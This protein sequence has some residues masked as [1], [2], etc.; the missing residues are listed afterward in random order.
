MKI[1]I[2]ETAIADVYYNLAAEDILCQ[3]VSSETARGE[4]LCGMFLWQSDK[5]VVIGR[6]QNPVREC[7]MEALRKNQ[8]KLARRLTGGGA[9]YQDLGNL[10]YSFI[11][12]EDSVS[13]ENNLKIVL[14]VLKKRGIEAVCS[15][16]NDIITLQ[17]RKI[18]GTAK[19]RYPHALLLHGTI[20]INLDK[21]MAEMCLTPGQY[22]LVNKGIRSVKAR[23][24]NMS[25]INNK[26]CVEN[27][28]EDM[29]EEFLSTYAGAEVVTQ[30]IQKCE[31]RKLYQRLA[32]DAWIM[33][34]DFSDFWIVEKRWGTVR[35]SLTE[36]MGYIES[37][38]YETDCMESDFIESFFSG[39]KGREPDSRNL[40]QYLESIKEKNG[41]SEQCIEIGTDLIEKIISELQ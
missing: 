8:V 32:D 30:D 41:L 11:S 37:V 18:S 34:K 16:R 6:N 28:R 17:N 1:F 27:I 29:K 4:R 22:K 2:C 9:V 3:H 35:F 13:V 7:N 14:N 10:N 38:K 33:G 5:A 26:C 31:I 23:I 39:L 21:N 40:R 15:G 20:L 25:E 19:K 36:K 12:S 24:I